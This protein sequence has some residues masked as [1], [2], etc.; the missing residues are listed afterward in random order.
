M[1]GIQTEGIHHILAQHFREVLSS[2]FEVKRTGG[3]GYELKRNSNDKLVLT[4]AAFVLLS[5]HQI[6]ISFFKPDVRK[7]S[8]W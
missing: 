4:Q 1:Q 2:S 3:T 5:F 6:R 7:R 8:H